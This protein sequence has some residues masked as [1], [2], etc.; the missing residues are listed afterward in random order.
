MLQAVQEYKSSDVK[1]AGVKKMNVAELQA[2]C[3]DL[4]IGHNNLSLSVV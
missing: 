1:K 4:N 2:H 3:K